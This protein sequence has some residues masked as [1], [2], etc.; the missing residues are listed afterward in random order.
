MYYTYILCVLHLLY[1]ELSQFNLLLLLLF[2]SYHYNF[3][4]LKT[5]LAIVK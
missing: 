3:T 2:L 5:L 1:N 4:W